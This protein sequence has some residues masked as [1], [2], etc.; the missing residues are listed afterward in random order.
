MTL[1]VI[2]KALFNYNFDALNKE[3]PVIQAVY[4][5]LKETEVRATALLPIWKLPDPLRL[6]FPA[7]RK[8]QDAVE[9]SPF[10]IILTHASHN[11]YYRSL[12]GS[13]VLYRG[14]T[15]FAVTSA[16]RSELIRLRT[17]KLT[18]FG[19]NAPCS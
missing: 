2:G 8:A 11:K 6:L 3:S 5:A 7:Q 18:I 17:M 12:T 9:V 16:S 10:A 15:S 1:D 14:T 19:N 13:Q 4:L